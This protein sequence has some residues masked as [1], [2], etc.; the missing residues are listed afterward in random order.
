[1]EEHQALS[2]EVQLGVFRAMRRRPES[3]SSK[4][5]TLVL[6]LIH[7]VTAFSAIILIALS[8]YV[9]ASNWGGLDPAFFFDIGICSLLFSLIVLLLSLTGWGSVSRLVKRYTAPEDLSNF[10]M[11]RLGYFE[12]IAFRFA[13]KRHLIILSMLL[14]TS[15]IFVEIYV[16]AQAYSAV[17]AFTSTIAVLNTQQKLM[18]TPLNV[19]EAPFSSLEAA[20]SVRFNTFFFGAG[21]S[22]TNSNFG[23][24]WDWISIH[25][26]SLQLDLNSCVS[27]GGLQQT[28]CNADSTSC[29]ANVSPLGLAQ[30]SGQGVTCPY[31]ICRVG[32]T[33]YMIS[34]V[35]PFVYTVLSVLGVQCLTLVLY[36]LLLAREF[37]T[38][39]FVQRIV[40]D[41]VLDNI[42]EAEMYHTYEPVENA[43]A[44]GPVE[45]AAGAAGSQRMRSEEDRQEEE[46]IQ[47]ALALSLGA[48]REEEEQREQQQEL[49]VSLAG[50]DD[51]EGEEEKGGE[52][53]EV[54]DDARE[55]ADQT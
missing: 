15:C 26:P 19:P 55:P 52:I 50:E 44:G 24:W 45:A 17:T 41:G 2:D 8:I 54:E 25:C 7:Q 35:N 42:Q 22:C 13:R 30:V 9:L 31:S 49:V 48:L 14:V 34:Q 29:Y 16:L 20:L 27:C 10:P 33:T 32:I 47:M 23:W 39:P 46:E 28:L 6:S 18:A 37:K 1:M 4:R 53:E 40:E 36:S 3:L 12:H 38:R 51:G 11:E 21:E 5:V 43:P